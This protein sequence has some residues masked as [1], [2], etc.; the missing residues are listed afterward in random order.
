[1]SNFELSDGTVLPSYLCVDN[2]WAG[3]LDVLRDATLRVGEVVEAISPTDSANK[4]SNTKNKCWVYIVNVSYRDG[5][6]A[7]SVV[8]YRCVVADLFGGLGDHFRH[9]V[10]RADKV[11]PTEFGAGSQ[12]IILCVNADKNDA[13]IVGGMRHRK[14]VSAD[15]SETFLDFVFNGVHVAIDKDGA[16]T[17]EVPGATKLDGSPD[18][19]RD[20]NNQGSKVTF[21]K[22][23]VITVD[24]NNGDSIVL[25]P[26]DKTVTIKA[27]KVVV[28]ADDVDVKATNVKVEATQATIKADLVNLGD[29]R[30]GIDPQDGVVVGSGIDTFTGS[31]Y[32][33]LGSTSLIV[34]AKKRP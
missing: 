1:M 30:T 22:D 12:V 18:D 5:T 2:D 31:P 25:S 14:D 6:G 19:N 13:L 32:F 33:A 9:T 16:L 8:P 15:P 24:D 7:R 11:L 4:D 34:S 17:V 10:R 28:E 27:S 29:E 26:A 21:A 20:S 3:A 23:G